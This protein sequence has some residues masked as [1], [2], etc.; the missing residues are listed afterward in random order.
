MYLFSSAQIVN[1]KHDD[2]IKDIAFVQFLNFFPKVDLPFNTK[3]FNDNEYIKNLKELPDSLSVRF[4]FHN[5]WRRINSH[6]TQYDMN[7]GKSS[8]WDVHVIVNPIFKLLIGDYFIVCFMNFEE[9]GQCPFRL[10]SFDY[11][12]NN[13]D[14]LT[15]YN[16]KG[17]TEFVYYLASF[18]DKKINI[19]TYKYEL[20][21]DKSKAKEYPTKLTIT[22]YKF[23]DK[24]GKIE[25]LNEDNVRYLKCFV[26]D[27]VNYPK[28]CKD[29]DPMNDLPK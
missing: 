18:I 7:S 15:I 17:I 13:L 20:V 22:K 26:D 29:D 14:N 28:K 3:I 11:N 27:I 1:K 2:V 12:G 6:Y 4:I 8:E 9:E 10:Q 24:T 25:F 23:D 19:T 16:T 5:D 21:E